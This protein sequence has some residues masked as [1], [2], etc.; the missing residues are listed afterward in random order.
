MTFKQE[1]NIPGIPGGDFN[2]VLKAF[3]CTFTS[4]GF[5]VKIMYSVAVCSYNMILY[6]AIIR[7]DVAPIGCTFDIY[8]V[9]LGYLE[10]WD[11]VMN[12]FTNNSCLLCRYNQDPQFPAYSNWQPA[13]EVCLGS[14]NDES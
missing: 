9:A 14:K 12:I 13:D 3:K 6:V 8:N 10:Y 5:N 4:A 7:F 2:T 11:V 1:E